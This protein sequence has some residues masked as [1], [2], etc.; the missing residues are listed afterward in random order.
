MH[1]S[2]F[3]YA[4]T[5]LYMHE[6][7]YRKI[8]LRRNVNNDNTDTTGQGKN[9][10]TFNDILICNI[11]GQERFIQGKRKCNLLAQRLNVF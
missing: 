7:E 4:H 6:I 9:A 3:L 5:Y 10:F 8:Y 11:V 1:N 2:Y